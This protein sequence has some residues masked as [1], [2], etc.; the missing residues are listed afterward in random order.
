MLTILD[1][2][3]LM[4]LSLRPLMMRVSSYWRQYTPLLVS[5]LQWILWRVWRPVRQLV[6]ILCKS[7]GQSQIVHTGLCY[8]EGLN[9]VCYM[10]IYLFVK[11]WRLIA[12][13]SFLMN[14]QSLNYCG[15]LLAPTWKIKNV[16]IQHSMFTYLSHMLT[17]KSCCMLP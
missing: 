17:Y 13:P 10:H 14:N 7:T 6:S 1:F 2:Q 8:T 11:Q 15:I 12:T 5:L 3:T 4:V 16:K 9:E